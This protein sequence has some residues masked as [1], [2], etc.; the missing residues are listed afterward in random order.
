M[1]LE[2]IGPNET[3]LGKQYIDHFDA[4]SATTDASHHTK[5]CQLLWWLNQ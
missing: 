3:C 1:R 4:L 2:E 5:L